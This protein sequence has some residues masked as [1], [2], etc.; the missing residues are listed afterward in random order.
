MARFRFAAPSSSEI[1]PEHVYLRRREL[2]GSAVAFAPALLLGCDRGTSAAPAAAAPV[3][4][5]PFGKVLRSPYRTDEALTELEDV[6]A[7][8]NYYEFG[9][10]KD[11]PARQSKQFVAKPW[12]V[13]IAGEAEV[14]G[15]FSFEDLVKPHAPEERIYRLRCVEAWSMVIPW[16]GFGLGDLLARFKPTSKA[17]YVAFTTLH[18]PDR[19]PGQRRGVL[20]WPYREGLRIDEAM[21]PLSMLAIGLYGRELPNQ[22]GAP[23]RLVVP[24]KYGYKSIKGIVRIEFVE[25]QPPTA[26]NDSAPNEYGFYSNVNPEVKHPRWSQKSERR[27]SQASGIFGSRIATLPFNGYG[28]DVAALYAGMDLRRF[29]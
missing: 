11:D 15:R 22:N 25:E 24:W 12:H 23:L 26:W 20:N 19:M 16:I 13:D 21:N 29:H 9:T 14:T 2:L 18:D 4:A 8:N 10:E 28:K 5:S 27:I 6:T 7:Y 17:K 3:P 1:T